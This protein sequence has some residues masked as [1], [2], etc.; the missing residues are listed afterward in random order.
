DAW[1]TLVGGLFGAMA[2]GYLE[3]VLRPLIQAGSPGRLTV[4]GMIGLPFWVV[5]LPLAAVLVLVLVVLERQ[6]PW[7]DDL[8]RNLD[9]LTDKP[10]L[11]VRPDRAGELAAE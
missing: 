4:H 10:G 1:A 3:P 5:A 11:K 8:G 6:R 7:R 2:F 9:G